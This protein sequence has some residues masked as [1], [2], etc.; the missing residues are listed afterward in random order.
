MLWKRG[1]ER[2]T[3]HTLGQSTASLRVSRSQATR[4]DIRNYTIFPQLVGPPKDN[5]V[6]AAISDYQ[7]EINGRFPG[8]PGRRSHV[9]DMED[10]RRCGSLGEINRLNNYGTY[11]NR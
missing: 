1:K 2:H 5:L 4:R 10:L 6:V 9:E 11:F 3:S 8:V 7:K